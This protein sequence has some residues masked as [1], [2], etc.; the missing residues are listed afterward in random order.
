MDR[1]HGTSGSVGRFGIER[2]EDRVVPSITSTTFVLKVPGPT[3]VVVTEA[4]NPGGNHPPG[5]QDATELSNRDAKQ[6]R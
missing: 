6:F 5:H 4:T 1:Q 3:D 2:L